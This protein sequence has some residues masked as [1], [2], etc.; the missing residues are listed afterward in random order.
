MSQGIVM[1]EEEGGCLAIPVRLVEGGLMI[2]SCY[3]TKD[4]VVGVVHGDAAIPRSSRYA[5]VACR[6][7]RELL[8]L[9][10]SVASAASR[11]ANP[12]SLAASTPHNVMS[13]CCFLC[14]A[15][16]CERCDGINH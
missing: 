9:H 1:E 2:A 10:A 14:E 16:P 3:A 13:L 12:E 5:C 6:S 11:S 4:S 8:E 7:G 15:R